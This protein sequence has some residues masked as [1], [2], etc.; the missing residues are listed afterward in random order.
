MKDKSVAFEDALLELQVIVLNLEK[1]ELPLDDALGLFKK[2]VELTKFC[3]KK[4]DD[5]E[6]K[7]SILIEKENGELSEANFSIGEDT[8]E[9]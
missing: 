9:L 8:N 5:A 2:G 4:L 6:K 7:I 1:G 3:N